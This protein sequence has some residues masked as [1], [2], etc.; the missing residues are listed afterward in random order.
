M[1]QISQNRPYHLCFET[2][3]NQLRLQI[4]EVLRHG[5][6]NV[7][8]L[9]MKLHAERSRVSH[10]LA[11]LKLCSYVDTKKQ[12]KEMIYSIKDNTPL[13]AHQPGT[14]I[15]AIVDNHIDSHCKGCN[16]LRVEKI[17]IVG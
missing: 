2:L 3:S 9:A 7:T 17:G 12:G 1:K 11:M 6:M 14:S 13:T 5:P 16:K 15:F 4:L 8:E 10:S